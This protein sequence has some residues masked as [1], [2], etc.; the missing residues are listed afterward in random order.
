ML[1]RW[2]EL[3]CRAGALVSGGYGGRRLECRIPKLRGYMYDAGNSWLL[4]WWTG[5]MAVLTG[6][7]CER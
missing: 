4:A 6:T 7:G 3:R 5:L 1:Q 2:R